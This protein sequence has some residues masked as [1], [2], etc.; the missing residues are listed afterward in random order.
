MKIVI[1]QIRPL[2]FNLQFNFP[3]LGLGKE[4]GFETLSK[5]GR[6]WEGF[7]S[8]TEV[9]N[10][11]LNLL[12]NYISKLQNALD[13]CGLLANNILIFDNR[14]FA[15]NFNEQLRNKKLLL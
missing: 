13:G 12:N 5:K 4:E 1:L 2:L 8:N 14:K 6:V 9:F 3:K 11:N 15:K 7:C 10:E